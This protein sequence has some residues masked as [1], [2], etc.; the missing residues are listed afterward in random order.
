MTTTPELDALRDVCA[1]LDRAGIACMLTGSLAMSLYVRPRMTRDVDL[2]V[3]L[4]AAKV[5]RLIE[6]LGATYHAEA[7]A[8]TT[9]IG[10][11]RPWNI[12]HMPT[13]VKIDPIPRKDDEYRRT[14][15][16]RRR[17]IEFAGVPLW[18]VNIEDLILSKLEWMRESGS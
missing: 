15:F 10:S 5:D 7:E 17:K 1:C 4:D 6:A 16:E 13:P 11:A 8:I 3:A 18:I 9:A 14:E 12:I 2:V